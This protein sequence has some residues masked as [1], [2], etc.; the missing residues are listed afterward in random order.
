MTGFEWT[1]VPVKDFVRYAIIDKKYIINITYSGQI[2]SES[3]PK[4]ER[5]YENS[6][7]WRKLS[8]EELEEVK[9]IYL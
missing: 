2:W 8:P 1:F 6:I 9:A 5:N 7:I 4:K 3:M